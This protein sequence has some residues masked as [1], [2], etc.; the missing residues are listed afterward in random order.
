MS[1]NNELP[2]R[3]ARPYAPLYARKTVCVLAA[4][5]GLGGLSIA[6]EVY[7]AACSRSLHNVLHSPIVYTAGCRLCIC[8]GA[9]SCT[10]SGSHSARLLALM[11]ML[12]HMSVPV[13][14][15]CHCLWFIVLLFHQSIISLNRRGKEEKRREREREDKAEREEEYTTNSDYQVILISVYARTFVISFKLL[16]C[17][18]N[19]TPII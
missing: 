18:L 17:S 12:C 6:L 19:C 3:T 16:N 10:E 7:R 2:E 8:F 15:L 14:E 9:G 11:V 4:T 13:S 5:F 1:L